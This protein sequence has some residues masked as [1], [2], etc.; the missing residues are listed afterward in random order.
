[1]RFPVSRRVQVPTVH[2]LGRVTQVALE[3]MRISVP[4]QFPGRSQLRRAIPVVLMV[5]GAVLLFYV[6]LQY[7]TMY[8]EQ[9]NLAREWQNE[10]T[11]VSALRRA[12]DGLTRLSIPKISLNAVVVEGT[13]HR[14]L[15]LG[16]G[17]I[18]D[19]P[20]PG[21]L[22]NAVITGHRDTFFRH[23][24]ELSKGDTITVQR[25]GRSYNY[26]VTGKKIV[27]PSDLSVIKPS[28]DSRLTL[29]TCYPTYYIGPAPERLVVFTKLADDS[30]AELTGAIPEAG[31]AADA[32]H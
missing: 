32:T 29:I 5:S 21:E 30:R 15:L 28:R 13:N 24:Y 19:T 26:E 14:S 16:P 27:D 10:Q 2:Q 18:K 20:A 17:H 9:R 23:I 11:A 8:S 7:W 6:G 12:N 22:G 31:K 25:N 3:R 1:M 4:R